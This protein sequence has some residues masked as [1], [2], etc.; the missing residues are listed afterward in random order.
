VSP[1]FEPTRRPRSLVALAAVLGLF[2]AA[3][4]SSSAPTTQAANSS[5]TIVQVSGTLANPWF[6]AEKNGVDQAAKDQ[7]V[8]A[9]FAATDV[10]G[11]GMA[12]ALQQAIAEHASGIAVHDWYP[13][14]E[15]SL[16]KQA[17]AAGIPL[18]EVDAAGDWQGAGALGFI[19]QSDHDAGVKGA[20]L[21]ATAGVHHLLF[22]N[23]A[24]GAINLET[25]WQAVQATLQPLGVS[26]KELNIS[27]AD[28]NNPT[29]V[30]QDIKGALVAD[31]SIDGIFTMGASIAE[32]AV[33]ASNQA[34]VSGKVKIGTTDLSTGDLNDIKAGTL[35]FALD[36]QPYLI[37]Y[38]AVTVLTQAARYGMHTV[39]Q[40]STGPS[41]IDKSNIDQV[42]ATNDKYKG[43]RGAA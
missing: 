29:Q 41:V 31:P 37:G 16:I 7:G 27:F 8:T 30:I 21:L 12:K 3:C 11:P 43:I 17:I 28:S 6:G 1:A 36:S 25:R 9:Q 32:D 10:T 13:S 20:Q 33:T 40:I 5:I 15:D 4:S 34:G 35:L 14:A 22:V 24:P 26:Y 23:H 38:Y 39:G 2:A 42:L 19:G 18:V